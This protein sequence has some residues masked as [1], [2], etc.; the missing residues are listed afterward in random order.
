MGISIGG[1][2]YF[3][4][5]EV[6]MIVICLLGERYGVKMSSRCNLIWFNLRVMG[7]KYCIC[8]CVC[9][10]GRLFCM[11]LSG[12]GFGWILLPIV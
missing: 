12:P 6:I 5:Q 11:C 1:T 2:I 10:F 7:M 8:L 4:V 9:S 3:K